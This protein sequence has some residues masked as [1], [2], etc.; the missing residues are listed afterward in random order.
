MSDRRMLPTALFVTAMATLWTCTA[1][2]VGPRYVRPDTPP[3]AAYR[4]SPPAGWS[5][6]Q[7]A[8]AVRRGDWW[9]VFREPAL[10]DLE[11]RVA[12]SNQNVRAAEAQYQE[13]RAAA[14]VAGAGSF[15][16]FR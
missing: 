14:R 5:V 9:T 8:D 12:I 15:R 1:C 3:S 16:S 10:D 13:A 11:G 6:A 2:A 7:P 4:E